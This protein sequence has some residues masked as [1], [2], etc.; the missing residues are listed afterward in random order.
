MNDK[1]LTAK[2]VA[3]YLR[4]SKSTIYKMTSQRII[5]FIKLNNG[6]VLFKLSDINAWLEKRKNKPEDENF[7]L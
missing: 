4:L 2:E 5:P 1:L 3:E 6:K 7:E